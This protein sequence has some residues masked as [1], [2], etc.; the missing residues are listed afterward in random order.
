MENV[1]EKITP[2]FPGW[3][4]YTEE[5]SFSKTSQNQHLEAIQGIISLELH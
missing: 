4:I 2:S 3:L 1:L 5:V